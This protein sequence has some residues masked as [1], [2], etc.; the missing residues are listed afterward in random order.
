MA[1]RGSERHGGVGHARDAVDRTTRDRDAR[2]GAAGP[3]RT[4]PRG[5][6]VAMLSAGD[7]HGAAVPGASSGLVR[8]LDGAL[9]RALDIVLAL[10][11]LVLTLPLLAAISL[12]IVLESRGCVLY[13]AERVGRDGGRL[14][15]LKFRKM[16]PNATGLPLTTD[17]D[18]RLT[19]LGRVLARTRLD[20]LPQLWHVV[21][22]DMSLVGP[23]PE[24]PIFVAER[25]ADYELILS[26]RPGMSGFAQLAFADERRILSASDP[27]TDYVERLLPQKCALDRL[28]VRTASFPTNVRVIAWTAV[29]ILLRRPVAVDRATGAL[30]LRRRPGRRPP[31]LFR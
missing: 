11:V 28:Y 24:D 16:R 10:T 8:G 9:M 2:E 25:P 13:R 7:R 19:R 14:R 22:G 6:T 29:A 30:G 18:A 27:V 31:E 12:A 3:H 20:E 21:R 26:V 23:R 1:A 15:M 5:A 17:G 4:G